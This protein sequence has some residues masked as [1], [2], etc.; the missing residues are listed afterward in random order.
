LDDGLGGE[1]PN[2]PRIPPSQNLPI[3]TCGVVPIQTW[4]RQDLD[5]GLGGE[6]LTIPWCSS[7]IFFA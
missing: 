4:L 5:D 1:P 6:P 2:V 3:Q 7:L